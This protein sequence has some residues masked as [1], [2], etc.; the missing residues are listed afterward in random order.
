MAAAKAKQTQADQDKE[1]EEGAEG[2]GKPAKA[3]GKFA[4]KLSRKMIDAL[5]RIDGLF[6]H[7][8][9]QC[10]VDDLLFSIARGE[11]RV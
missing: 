1:P 2:G 10:M 4:P 8:N 3:K 11:C 5:F 7:Y 9:G 6:K